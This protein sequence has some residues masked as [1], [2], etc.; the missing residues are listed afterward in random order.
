MADDSENQ[1]IAGA[2]TRS[3]LEPDAEKSAKIGD[4]AAVAQAALGDLA[5]QLQPET[6]PPPPD[7]F[8]DEP[9]LFAGPVK[10]VAD[11][12]DSPKGRGRR[13]GSKNKSNQLFR[14]YLLSMGYRHPGLNLADMANADPMQLAKQLGGFKEQA[15]GKIVYCGCTPK[16]A[17][18]L[19]MKANDILFPYFESKRPTEVEVTE[20]RL[21]V[22]QINMGNSSKVV[23]SEGLMSITGEIAEKVDKSDT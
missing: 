6:D 17:Y 20:Q 15:D 19:I 18:E 3:D 9:S 1:T 16:E 22:L 21:H 5:Q 8:E 13:K 7:L 10:H 11:I 14:D 23:D 12:L 4:Q 2:H